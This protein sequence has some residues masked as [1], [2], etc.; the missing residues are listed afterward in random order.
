[1]A[2]PCHGGQALVHS[3][4]FAWLLDASRELPDDASDL[5]EADHDDEDTDFCFDLHEDAN[6]YEYDDS[7]YKDSESKE[8]DLDESDAPWADWKE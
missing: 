2:G 1:M 4:I 6:D 3:E 5:C 7:E 8:D